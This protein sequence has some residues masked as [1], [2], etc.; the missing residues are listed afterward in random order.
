MSANEP[1][2]TS[3]LAAKSKLSV[4]KK[5]IASSVGWKPIASALPGY[6]III[7]VVTPLEKILVPNLMFIERQAMPNLR[8]I[9][10]V[11]DRPKE[12]MPTDVESEALGK[13]ASL[14]MEFVYWGKSHRQL[15]KMMKHSHGAAWLSWC[16]GLAKVQTNHVFLHH[17]DAFHLRKD[18]IEE[19]YQA[20][21]DGT[22]SYVGCDFFEDDQLAASDGF[23]STIEL[24]MDAELVRKQL[25]PADLYRQV[26]KFRNRRLQFEVFT[27]AQAQAGSACKIPI[28]DDDMVHLG[29][30]FHQYHQV[31][32]RQNVLMPEFNNL[33]LLPYLLYV[34]GKPGVL[35]E[36][37]DAYDKATT[38]M[39]QIFDTEMD[40]EYLSHNHVNRMMTQAFAIEKEVVGTVRPEVSVYFDSIRKFI[41]R[42]DRGQL[43][44]EIAGLH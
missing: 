34:A 36:H 20:T 22:E 5:M 33:P 29:K 42:R 16:L 31:M 26:T 18:L 28:Q 17:F 2:L 38:T 7:P 21:L 1:S 32:Q 27:Y 43:K 19:R 3:F 4:F 39:V 40:I 14:P 30:V 13:F 11:C 8:S 25:K 35:T 23:V 9:I 12:A 41:N 24:F 6:S 10:I 44:P 15:Y 37:R